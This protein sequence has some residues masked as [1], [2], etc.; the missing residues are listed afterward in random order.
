LFGTPEAVGHNRHGIRQLHDLDE[1]TRAIDRR[2]INALELA[3]R[4]WAGGNR[5]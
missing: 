3:A 4:H 1:A 2:L 5:A